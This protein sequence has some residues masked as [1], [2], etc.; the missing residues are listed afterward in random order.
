MPA[1]AISFIC[2]WTTFAFDDEY[3][4]REGKYGVESTGVP[5]CS[6]YQ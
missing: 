1:S 5:S 2:A 6:T 4:P 3:R